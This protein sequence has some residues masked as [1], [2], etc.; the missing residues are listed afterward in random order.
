VSSLL[1]ILIVG[2]M[3]DNYE[4]L[5]VELWKNWVFFSIVE[6]LQDKSATCSP[7]NLVAGLNFWRFQGRSNGYFLDN[8]H[9]LVPRLASSYFTG[10]K[11]NPRDAA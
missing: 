4:R 7:S 6:V 1:D 10:R 2:A 5:L 8:V 9:W 3:L 11:T